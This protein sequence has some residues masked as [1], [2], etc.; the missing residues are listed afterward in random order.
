MTPNLTDLLS[1][2]HAKGASD[3]HLS[4]HQPVMARIDGQMMPLQLPTL[5]HQTVLE[6]MRSVMSADEYQTWQSQK[7]LDFGIQTAVARFRVNAFFGQMGAGAV[8]RVIP[9]SVPSLDALGIAP[10][11]TPIANQRTGL[12]LVT[13][14]TGSGKSTTLS[15]IINH[16]NHTRQA[17]IITI[18]DPIEFIHTSG[19]SLITQRQVGRDTHSFEQALRASLREDPDVI[20]VGEMRDLTTIRLAL[21]A[22]ETG[23]LVLATLHTTS[24]VKSIDRI[25]DVFDAA[26]KSLIRTMLADSLTAVI[27]QRLLPAVG[28]GRVPAFEILT[29]TPAVANLIRENKPSQLQSVIQTSQAHGM[30]SLDQ[31]LKALL[32]QGK[33]SIDTAREHASDSAL[34]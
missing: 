3:L 33:I 31:S 5:S 2:A 8:F 18:E 20:L 13:G 34:F 1:F 24:A 27:A 21:T 19:A 26:E 16:I 4:A 15:A 22:A 25:V 7:E 12:V 9:S 32:A 30:I 29:R 11:I 10:L 14:A 28:G 23:H 17:H 6:M